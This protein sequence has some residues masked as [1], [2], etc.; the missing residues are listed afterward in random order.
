[1]SE[2]SGKPDDLVERISAVLR[3]PE[4]LDSTFEDRLVAALRAET[5]VDR[6]I[7][8]PAVATHHSWWRRPLTLRVTPLVGLA[9]AASF[10]AVVSL[11]T[12]STTRGTPSPVVAEVPSETVHVVRFVFV[13]SNARS[14]AL[15]GDFNAWKPDANSF[16]KQGQNGAWTITVPLTPGRHEYAFIV[17]GQRWAPDP[18][19]TPSIDEFDTKSSVINVGG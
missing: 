1:M 6:A 4:Q 12:L 5:P 19:A 16:A 10:S 7:T 18:F 3:Q 8:E 15:V 2:H 9:A 17:D 14:V 13:D 11:A